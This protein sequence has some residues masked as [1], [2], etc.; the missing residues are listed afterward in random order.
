[1]ALPISSSHAASLTAPD[2]S[3]LLVV[4]EGFDGL[5][6]VQTFLSRFN[7]RVDLVPNPKNLREGLDKYDA[8]IVVPPNG[9][10]PQEAAWSELV[11]R[12]EQQQIGILLIGG[13]PEAGGLTTC[14]VSPQ[15]S[16]DELTGRVQTMMRYRTILQG[17]DRELSRLQRLR[18]RLN[19]HFE[20]LDQEM[21]LA[22]RL[23]RDFLPRETPE[24]GPIRFATLYRP[25]TWVSGDIYDVFRLDERHV[26]FYLADAV[27]HGVAAG[28]LTMFIKRA[29]LTK[30]IEH[31]RYRIVPPGEVLAALNDA[32]AA[33]QLPNCQFV[34]VC[35]GIVNYETLQM[36]VAR[37]G[38]PY[39]IHI[40]RNGVA[41]EIESEGGLLGVFP[42]E[43][44]PCASTQLK[45]GE[46]VL[47]YSDGL[48]DVLITERDP[49]TRKARYS[50]ILHDLA[51]MPAGA[52]VSHLRDIINRN[53][54]SLSPADDITALVLEV[55]S[56]WTAM[57]G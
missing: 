7:G 45:P 24:V 29:M 11:T 20:E 34:T 26:G 19:R 6:H 46:K 28:L 22:S 21:R 47:I 49:A 18:D 43:S 3:R 23:Q 36:T 9:S 38:H 15:A 50:A 37:G 2:A 31:G 39:P 54:G 40:H 53:E 14:W 8:A 44:Y 12:L 25:A 16:A 56:D 13:T 48:E 27:G 30:V 10:R 33:Q 5:E 51:G 35:Y 4:A 55:A 1:M 41:E 52:G 57:A 32:L 42:D 17:T